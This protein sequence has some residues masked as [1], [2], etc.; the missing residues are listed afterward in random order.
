M[1]QRDHQTLPDVRSKDVKF[2]HLYAQFAT[3][4]KW[5]RLGN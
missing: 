3:S 1:V 4:E 5:A 2:L